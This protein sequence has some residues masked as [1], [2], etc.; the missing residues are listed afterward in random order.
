MHHKLLR[1]EYAY[2][3][4]CKEFPLKIPFNQQFSRYH[5]NEARMCSILP[6]AI[7]RP[8]VKKSHVFITNQ[9]KLS[10]FLVG[11]SDADNVYFIASFDHKTTMNVMPVRLIQSINQCDQ[12]SDDEL[13]T[14]NFKNN[15]REHS[16][17]TQYMQQSSLETRILCR[18][19][20]FVLEYDQLLLIFMTTT[21]V[22]IGAGHS[23]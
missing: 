7:F 4:T 13:D 18:H 14:S 17:T 2:I 19:G 8:C 16:L 23:Q 3:Y 22:L 1:P 21:D 6:S 5:N 15:K 9:S 11:V 12:G 20:F 10:Q